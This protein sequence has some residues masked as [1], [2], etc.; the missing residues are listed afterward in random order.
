MRLVRGFKRRDQLLKLIESQ[1]GEIQELGRARLH[2]GES[3]TGHLWCLLSWEAEYT[4]IGINSKGMGTETAH[5][6]VGTQGMTHSARC[7]AIWAIRRAAH[8]GQNPRRLQLKGTSSSS[9]QVSQPSRRKPWARMP[10]R[11]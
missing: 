5:W 11:K 2:I 1:T 4:I 6:R 7:A 9:W 8:E 3:Y 10:H